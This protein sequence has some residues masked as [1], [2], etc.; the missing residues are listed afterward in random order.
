ML[1][2]IQGAIFD[3]DGTLID[4]MWVWLKVDIDYLKKR[5]IPM[6]ENLKSEIE[7]LSFIDCARYFKKTF[8]LPETIEEIMEEWN[9]MAYTEYL[10]NVQVKEG[11]PAF[12]KKLKASGTKLALATSNCRLLLEVALKKFQ[13][14]DLFDAIVVTD[15]VGKP[16]SEPDV[17]LKA[18]ELIGVQPSNCVVFEDILPAVK[19]AKKAG[20]KVV[21]ISDDSSINQRE[22][23]RLNADKFIKEYS[24]LEDV[25]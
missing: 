6:P 23:I 2:D 7:H 5:N 24:E 16:K 20:M 19:S 13:I 22:E 8:S 12:L 18:A 1:K 25:I 4:S 9:T 11:V 10:E 3:M 21:A 15:E 17:F 14:Y